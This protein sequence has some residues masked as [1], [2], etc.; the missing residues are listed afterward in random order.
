MLIVALFAIG[1]L[2]YVV[3]HQSTLIFKVMP[4][5]GR[6]MNREDWRRSWK[7]WLRGTAIGFR[8]GG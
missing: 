8:S 4:F 7:P 3:A 6:W 5:A 2:F 1:E